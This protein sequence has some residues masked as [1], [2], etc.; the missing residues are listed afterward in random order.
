[1]LFRSFQ[2]GAALLLAVVIASASLS[3]ADSRGLSID[4]SLVEAGRVSLAVYD[5]EGCMVRPILYGQPQAPGQ[6]RFFWDGLDRYGDAVPAGP[7]EWRLLW[8]PGFSREFL[9][10]VGIN[11]PWSP[12]D[13]WP[14]NHFGPNVLLVDDACLYVGSISS[15]GPPHLEKIRLDGGAKLWDD[16]DTS[17][18]TDGL[19]GLARIG[20]VLY[21]QMG[22]A[23]DLRRAD[24]GKKFW[25][26]DKLH[27]FAEKN[28][29]FVQLL[30]S[31][32][33]SAKKNAKTNAKK[34]ISPM[35][36]AAGKDFL[37][38]TY[39]DYNELR[40]LWPVDD[41]IDREKTIAIP[42]AGA[43]AASADGQL[44]V[45]SGN[46]LVQIDPESGEV[47]P[48]V[49]DV[50]QPGKLAYD[51]VFH[52]L[53]V[54]SGEQCIRRYHVPDGTPVAVYGRPEGRSY[55]LFNPLDFDGI[56]DLV[57]DRHGGFLTA[58]RYPR[59]VTHF[60]GREQHE[61]VNQ[62][63]GGM[64]WGSQATIDP[65]DPKIVYL[66]IDNKHLGRG[67]I[68]YKTKS[69]ALTHLYDTI[70]HGSWT[71]GKLAHRDILPFAGE[72]IFWEVRHIGEQTFLIS[73]GA[74]EASGSVT[75]L[76]VDENENRLWPVAH[77]GGLH[78]TEDR[79]KLPHWWVA[80]LARI[81][82]RA[83]TFEAAGKYK[84]FAF[85]WSDRNE[86]GLVEIPEISLASVGVRRGG[87]S[88]FV[89]PDWNVICPF[90]QNEIPWTEIRNEGTSK[91]PIWN[92]DHSRSAAA[93]YAARENAVARPG[94]TSVFR[95]HEGAIYLTVNN[96]QEVRDL[97][98]VPPMN[99]PNN[100]NHTSRF[101]KWDPRGR[102]VFSVGLHTDSKSE[103]PGIFADVRA[104]LG[105]VKDCLV[106]MDACSPANVW[107]R[108]GLYAGAFND[109]VGI[110]TNLEGWQARA[111]RKKVHDDNQWGQ[112]T[113]T[114]DGDVLWGQLRDNSTPFY[115][116]TGW[117]HWQ[118]QQG[119]LTLETTSTAATRKGEGLMGAYFASFELSGTPFHRRVDRE[120]AFGP[121]HGDHR[122][123]KVAGFGV[124]RGQSR[125]STA[126]APL[127]VRWTGAL[128]APLSEDFTF[129][130]YTYG[131]QDAGARVRLWIDG[132]LVVD[133]WDGI[134]LR[135][136]LKDWRFTRELSSPAVAL[137]AGKLVPIKI[138]YASAGGEDEHLHLYWMSRSYDLRHVPKE[139]LYPTGEND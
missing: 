98:D 46:D 76:R 105:E 99:W 125:T 64:Q 73:R 54:V 123:V 110:G 139:Y 60:R 56:L 137:T 106:V 68:D 9:V 103:P 96:A 87:Y 13:V 132:M 69:W 24:T 22:T 79:Q 75:V 37:A 118:R 116:I 19:A 109:D 111:F 62:W 107:T 130:I 45:V 31:G 70:D 39:R 34:K 65:A 88:C 74:C 121:M 30:H 86:N 136:S 119:P 23:L 3:A 138:E 47:S 134:T 38:V 102:Q 29:P 55:G 43:V 92:W 114:A 91:L 95:D 122:V 48:I 1:M 16:L 131:K 32:D 44:F 4:Y 85:S 35:G 5:V 66:P 129:R 84:H 115:R 50:P 94:G 67:I 51:D 15:E 41:R 77:L 14:G 53:L 20:N 10:N 40:L 25:G 36:L 59:R 117:D 33:D 52:D 108:D 12:F 17:R 49:R 104:I 82:I 71:L 93:R 120:I 8:T 124:K 28:L 127:S 6:Y 57:T 80:A 97:A 89:G 26:H 78:P 18:L 101:L 83:T 126:D 63:F 58:E 128:E 135:G 133:S 113:E 21:L 100:K 11:T 112:L 2:F 7:Y 61:V 42:Q 90:S 27:R 72:R 81:G